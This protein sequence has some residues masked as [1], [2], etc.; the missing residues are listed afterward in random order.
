VILVDTSVWVD[1]WRQS[2]WADPLAGLIEDNLVLTHDLVVAELAV[3]KLGP[4]R[5][6]DEILTGLARLPKAVAADI[7][8]VLALIQQERLAR[9]GLG[10]V[11]VHLLASARMSH[12]LLWTV[13]K[14]LT[15]AAQNLGLAYRMA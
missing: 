5:V 11:D 2:S 14:S 8:E 3:G 4:T 13:D 9:Q 6:R 10:A 7:T 12:A 1:F 15:A